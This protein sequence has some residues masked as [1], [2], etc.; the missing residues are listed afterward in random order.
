MKEW[1]KMWRE[2]EG[3][4]DISWKEGTQRQKLISSTGLCNALFRL[5]IRAPISRVINKLNPK[6][7]GFC[8]YWWGLKHR[9]CR[10][11]FAGLMAAMGNKGFDDFLKWCESN[12]DRKE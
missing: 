9:D 10:A 11:T 2:I 4:F 8:Q 6:K 3:A 12:P 7:N 1:K 5:G